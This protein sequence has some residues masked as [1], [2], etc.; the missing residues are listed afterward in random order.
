MPAMTASAPQRRDVMPL[1]EIWVPG[2]VESANALW[3]RH[4]M[5][6][7]KRVKAV[8]TQVGQIAKAHALVK[9]VTLTAPVAV[10]FCMVRRRLFDR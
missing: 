7:H 10:A 3:R 4:P 5:Q 8:V 2:A 1:L 9:Q 6:R